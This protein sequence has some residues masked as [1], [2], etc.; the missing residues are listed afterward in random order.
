MSKGALAELMRVDHQKFQRMISQMH[1][2]EKKI[3]GGELQKRTKILGD[4]SLG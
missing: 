2:T 3:V 4:P 1:F